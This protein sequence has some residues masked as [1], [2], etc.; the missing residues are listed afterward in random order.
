M[1]HFIYPLLTTEITIKEV[2]PQYTNNEYVTIPRV[3]T[4]S[5]FM[6]IFTIIWTI[7]VNTFAILTLISFLKAVLTDAG[8]V[9]LEYINRHR[10]LIRLYRLQ[11][12]SSMALRFQASPYNNNNNNNTGT[13]RN[14]PNFLRGSTASSN[15]ISN[16]SNNNS[17][18]S[19]ITN[20]NY[21]DTDLAGTGKEQT[22]DTVIN[23]PS[24]S[25]SSSSSS[26]I[27]PTSIAALPAIGERASTIIVHHI[28]PNL[29]LD[30]T[31][32]DPRFCKKCSSIKPPRTHHCSLCGRCVTKMDHH[33]P[34]IA[35]C[36]GYNNYKYFYLLL[37]H[38]FIS[39]CLALCFWS[40]TMFSIVYPLQLKE[41]S[42]YNPNIQYSTPTSFARAINDANDDFTFAHSEMTGMFG[43][44]LCISLSA[45]L[46]ALGG[47]HT[48]L[49][50]TNKT[51]LESSSSGISPYYKGYRNNWINVMGKNP[52]YWFLP[53]YTKDI[54]E[55]S[56]YGTDFRRTYSDPI[57]RYPIYEFPIPIEEEETEWQLYIQNQ[58]KFL[59]S[60][61]NNNTKNNN[62]HKAYELDIDLLKQ[63]KYN[64]NSTI[65]T[66][67]NNIANQDDNED[68]HLTLLQS[69]IIPS[70][71]NGR[72]YRNTNKDN[73]HTSVH[74]DEDE[75]HPYRGRPVL[76]I[77]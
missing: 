67:N 6:K 1:T 44:I 24:S 30:P 71:N 58:Q 35:N 53:I 65:T 77:R 25:S 36:V 41:D 19:N 56:R 76:K 12:S 20:N 60:P 7:I 5:I 33:C 13:N 64:P 28:H 21:N 37:V 15:T 16:N 8:T 34:W 42:I 18:T 29:L 52:L 69:S 54:H 50:L 3:F 4:A 63:G 68:E 73:K 45:S 48:Y 66:S 26:S 62:K 14:L 43:F 51:T 27:P 23:I 46:I 38:G 22:N 47:L 75:I 31:P 59:T 57:N 72:I 11:S 32:H 49:I 70:D 74:E 17:M 61:T 9:P 10:G 2:T 55:L 39:C 40:L